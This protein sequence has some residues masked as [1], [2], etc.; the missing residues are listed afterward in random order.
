MSSDLV[1]RITAAYERDRQ[2][3]PS[4][5]QAH[6][7]PLSFD[8][9]TDEWL[10]AALCSRTAGAAVVGHRLGPPDTGT[11]NRRF[12][13][14]DYNEAGKA[15]GLPTALFAKATH[16]LL[17]RIVLGVAGGARGEINFY[18]AI[19]PHLSIEAPVS[20]YAK[21][22]TETY[23]SIVLLEDLTGSVSEF[24]SQTT[25]MDFERV[26]SQLS[27]LAS[28]HGAC[29]RGGALT[30]SLKQFPTWPEFFGSTLAMGMKEGSSH[31]FL[32][33]ESV[34]P[35]RLFKR[36]E[37]VWPATLASVDLHN[38]LPM[39]LAHGDVHL[40]NWY[41]TNSGV[42]GLSDWQCC[43][44][45]HWSRDVAYAVSTALTVEDRRNWEEELIRFYLDH[46]HAA[47]GPLVSLQ[48][49]LRHYRQ[50]LLSSLTWWTITLAPAPGMPDM[51]PKETT[52]E[53]I[54]RISAAIDDLEAL[55]AF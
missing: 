46:L 21:F 54:R 49:G 19:R 28:L 13:Y 42:M 18:N 47:G 36:F 32:A 40:K 53:F 37:D 1:A 14:V 30:A 15:A 9:M 26:C 8:E 43:G 10:T 34:I 50:Q 16:D 35:S 44:R 25:R 11:S 48:E 12:I 23:N 33:A 31:G 27:L 22:D 3:N 39:T 5:R 51:Q 17:N 38:H 20:V 24:C 29:Y 7:L 52:L 45:A 41:V 6:E 2:R 55:N 4:D